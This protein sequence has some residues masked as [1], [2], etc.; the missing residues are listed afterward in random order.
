MTWLEGGVNVPWYC[1]WCQFR[2]HSFLC[3]CKDWFCY[4]WVPSSSYVSKE[5][6]SHLCEVIIPDVLL[7]VFLDEAIDCTLY[8]TWWVCWV[9]WYVEVWVVW[10]LVGSCHDSTVI[11]PYCDIKKVYQCW[12]CC[13]ISLE[14]SKLVVVMLHLFPFSICSFQPD[15]KYII[16]ESEVGAS[17]YLGILGLVC[18]FCGIQHKGLQ[19]SW[20]QR[21]P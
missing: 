17:G 20:Q 11:N 10:F 7:I 8:A 9:W 15:S 19:T 13:E 4:V 21:Y 5:E 14:G 2:F 1:S 6:L 16:D 3:W 12:R 18:V